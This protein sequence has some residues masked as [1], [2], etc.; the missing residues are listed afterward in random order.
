M[1]YWTV[2]GSTLRWHGNV[3]VKLLP[4]NTKLLSVHTVVIPNRSVA[5]KFYTYPRART[6]ELYNI[7]KDG[8]EISGGFWNNRV[9]AWSLARVMGLEMSLRNNTHINL[10]VL[11][12]WTCTYASHSPGTFLGEV[13]KP[14]SLTLG[15]GLARVRDIAPKRVLYPRVC[16]DET[17]TLI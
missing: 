2:K 7:L 13:M 9:R 5:Q 15:L 12:S 14:Q 1:L 16:L 8:P 3:H 6:G 4:V 11:R 17:N 10:F